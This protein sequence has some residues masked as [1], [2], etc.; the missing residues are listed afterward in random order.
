MIY[1]LLQAMRISLAIPA[2]FGIIFS[3]LLLSSG[4]ITYR[5]HAEQNFTN[6]G[7][8]SFL[9]DERLGI[10]QNI[11]NGEF[12]PAMFGGDV[13]PEASRM[14]MRGF[15]GYF[16]NG[17]YARSICGRINAGMNC[18]V[19]PDGG[20]RIYGAMQPDG[21]F[22]AFNS[23]RDWL[24]LKQTYTYTIR[25]V[26]LAG[27]FAYGD[28]NDSARAEAQ[29]QNLRDYLNAYVDKHIDELP[30]TSCIGDSPL[31]CGVERQDRTLDVM[32][33]PGQG[34]GAGILPNTRVL[35][36]MCSFKSIDQFSETKYLDG[37]VDLGEAAAVNR[38]LSDIGLAGLSIPC[39]PGT[40]TL[41]LEVLYPA[42]I[43]TGAPDLLAYQLID[44]Q[45]IQWQLHQGLLENGTTMASISK[46]ASGSFG[47]QTV[48]F[49]AG[50]MRGRNFKDLNAIKNAGAGGLGADVRFDYAVQFPDGTINASVNGQPLDMSGNRVVIDLKH[51]AAYGK[52]DGVRVVVVNYLSPLGPYTWLAINLLFLFIMGIIVVLNV[53]KWRQAFSKPSRKMMDRPDS[54]RPETGERRI[55]K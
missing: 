40:Q 10:D 27:F 20:V 39:D 50:Q 45:K 28:M 5:T 55:R 21:R 35:R 8:S 31:G 36:A 15:I 25:R 2:L 37:G 43:G 49:M 14:M 18:T 16:N 13:G 1:P 51:L 4:C 6:S 38:T 30:D 42:G 17:T 46:Y 48:D 9:L 23:T 19:T 26:P 11:S 53:S 34:A 24:E 32:L 3:M 47:E 41:V 7:D 44:R 12:S 29:R 22:Y 52:G 33:T 54:P